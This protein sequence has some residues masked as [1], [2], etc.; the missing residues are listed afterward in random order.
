MTIKVKSSSRAYKI[1]VHVIPA[2]FD[3][4]YDFREPLEGDSD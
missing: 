4:K 2:D 3:D 1:V